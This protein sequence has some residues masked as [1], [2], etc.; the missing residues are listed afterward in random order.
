MRLNEFTKQPK[1][2]NKEELEAYMLYI[3]ESMNQTLDE[4]D[5]RMES[6]NANRD[7]KESSQY[8]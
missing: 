2:M 8:L 6:E 4:A 7:R 3:L 1:D 5:R